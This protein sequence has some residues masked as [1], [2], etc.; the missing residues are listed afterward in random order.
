M[1][2]CNPG[3]T[4][5]ISALVRVRTEITIREIQ[6]LQPCIEPRDLWYDRYVRSVPIS[7]VNPDLLLYSVN[8]YWHLCV[9]QEY[10]TGT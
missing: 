5:L 1:F 6:Y 10:G 8:H 2:F 7:I 4:F 3:Q 9:C